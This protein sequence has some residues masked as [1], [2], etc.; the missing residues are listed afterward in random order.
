MRRV[1]FDIELESMMRDHNDLDKPNES[2]SIP[3][4]PALR[5]QR[6]E[7][8]NGPN[9]YHSSSVIRAV[10]RVSAK[11]EPL[12]DDE[13]RIIAEL[14]ERFPRHRSLLVGDSSGSHEDVR[15]PATRLAS[16]EEVVLEAILTTESRALKAM[17][18][19]VRIGFSCILKPKEGDIFT[20]IWETI[21]PAVSRRS[22]TVALRGVAEIYGK[23]V[24]PKTSFERSNRRLL[25][26]AGRMRVGSFVSVLQDIARERRIP[27]ELLPN[28]YLRLGEGSLQYRF[29]DKPEHPFKAQDWHAEHGLPGFGTV[30]VA[31]LAEALA[32]IRSLGLPLL[33]QPPP[34]DG[35]KELPA[36]RLI[37]QDSEAT[38]Y[39]ETELINERHATLREFPQGDYFRVLVLNEK[40]AAALR[41]RIPLLIG[42]GVRSIRELLD[43]LN[44]EEDR[45]DMRVARIDVGEELERFLETR[46][47]TLNSVLPRDQ[48]LP[49]V[50]AYSLDRGAVPIDDTEALPHEIAETAMRAARAARIPVAGVDLVL[51]RHDDGLPRQDN[52]KVAHVHPTPELGPHVWPREGCSRP[53]G[54]VV[55]DSLLG[56][57][58]GVIPKVVIAGDRGMARIARKVDAKLREEGISTAL[59]L[60]KA[61]YIGGKRA[62]RPQSAQFPIQRLLRNRKVETLVVSASLR[63]AA[64][65]GFSVSRCTVLALLPRVR[66]AR[67]DAFDDGLKLLKHVSVCFGVASVEDL[68]SRDAL[69]HLPCDRVALISADFQ[70]EPAISD[71]LA[72]GGIV[73]QRRWSAEG[74]RMVLLRGE[75]ALAEAPMASESQVARKQIEVDLYAFVIGSLLQQ[76][77]HG[78]V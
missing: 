62:E 50:P 12:E 24:G 25:S 17:G 68:A 20:V 77:R 36:E 33:F 27:E 43:E 39:F 59:N 63:R 78:E 7:M 6:V 49:L 16:F 4:Q 64:L 46:S 76:E 5:L 21:N 42:D 19:R 52:V 23:E 1:A 34:S 53:V 28:R 35:A 65:E 74:P 30:Q 47:L 51:E 44:S 57:S 9:K 61:D 45:D 22:L 38:A 54:E 15:L 11:H 60:R 58:E 48:Q 71:H 8:L 3:Q 29:S 26:R 70:E 13:A 31:T 18:Y 55:V 41:L 32:A 37:F 56:V 75:R 66:D 73:L 40:V 69:S 72:R 67:V 2:A 14:A 10:F